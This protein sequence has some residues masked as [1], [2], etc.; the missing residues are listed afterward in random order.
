[1][2]ICA[3]QWVRACLQQDHLCLDVIENYGHLCYLSLPL[4]WWY[5]LSLLSSKR[6][7]NYKGAVW[8]E[9]E[10]SLKMQQREDCLFSLITI[11]QIPPAR[12]SSQIAIVIPCLHYDI[13]I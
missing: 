3:V 8:I 12:Q 11:T 5:L 1:M 2:L 9:K 7:E 4:N 6:L 13:L 10:K